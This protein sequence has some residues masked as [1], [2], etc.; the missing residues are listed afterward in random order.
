MLLRLT[1]KT[2][3]QNLSRNGNSDNAY[4]SLVTI[5]MISNSQFG[6]ACGSVI[7]LPCYSWVVWGGEWGSSLQTSFIGDAPFLRPWTTLDCQGSREWDKWKGTLFHFLW[8]V[9]LCFCMQNNRR[10]F[11]LEGKG[12]PSREGDGRVCAGECERKGFMRETR[13]KEEGEMWRKRNK[14]KIEQEMV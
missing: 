1:D 12:I 14:W 8:P 13:S 11:C 9:Q 6:W 3:K 4:F 7:F 10:L 5:F 2:A